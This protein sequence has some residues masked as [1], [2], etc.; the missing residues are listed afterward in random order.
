MSSTRITLPNGST[1]EINNVPNF[2]IKADGIYKNSNP[3]E[4]CSS[5]VWVDSYMSLYGTN[6]AYKIVK[7]INPT[8]NDVFEIHIKASEFTSDLK[9][10][11]ISELMT[12]GCEVGYKQQGNLKEFLIKQKPMNI[13]IATKQTGWHEGKDGNNVFVLPD[14]TIGETEPPIVLF[15]PEQ[16]AASDAIHKNSSLDNEKEFV[17]N[18]AQGNPFLIFAIGIA[19][20]S[21]LM[22]WL[23]LEGCGFHFFGHSSR[24]KTILLQVMSAMFG[25]GG[26]PARGTRHPYI[27]TWDSTLFGLELLAHAFNHVLLALDELHKNTDSKLASIIYTLLGGTGKVRGSGSLT[28]RERNE[29]LNMIGSTGEHSMQDAIAKIDR[30]KQT[31]GQQIRMLDIHVDGNDILQNTF[32][33]SGREFAEMLKENCSKYFGA[34]G[35]AFIEHIHSIVNDEEK[36]NALIE[37][38]KVI[39]S[40]LQQESMTPEQQRVIPR[41]A[42]ISLALEIASQQQ[43]INIECAEAQHAVGMILDRWIESTS[44]LSDI[45]QGIQNIRT[46]ILSQPRKFLVKNS[47]DKFTNDIVGYKDD[48][49]GMYLI[50]PD[51]FEKVCGKSLTKEILNKLRSQ[52]FLHNNNQGRNVSKHSIDNGVS[53]SGFYAIPFSF[54]DEGEPVPEL[55]QQPQHQVPH[56]DPFNGS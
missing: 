37:R 29:W 35:E 42:A 7:G 47:V 43:L 53:Y 41:F 50:I 18:F 49:K 46:F 44:T 13:F 23:K 51:K 8:T 6:E 4:P 11:L 40:E 36:L 45:D 25:N 28:L 26:D 16:S 5:L 27:Q 52:G 38:H 24:G 19:L 56:T 17:S 32:E 15:N 30:R 10:S 33:R 12:H 39:A 54:M 1:V 34:T 3:N 55:T 22:K 20:T 21:V 31:T 9:A 48:D 2:L 14:K